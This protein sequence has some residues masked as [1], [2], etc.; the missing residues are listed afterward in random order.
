MQQSRPAEE[1]FGDYHDHCL[2]RI[3][4]LGLTPA[5]IDALR[6]YGLPA[7]DNVTGFHEG[8][9]GPGRMDTLLR[10][11]RHAARTRQECHYVEM[12][13]HNLGGLNAALGHAG[14]NEVFR[15]IAAVIREALSSAAGEAVFFRHG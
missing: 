7:D 15:A 11:I 10:A 2:E 12:D 13:V 3:R 5:Q 4:A 6:P 9:S 8:R 14:A 1:R